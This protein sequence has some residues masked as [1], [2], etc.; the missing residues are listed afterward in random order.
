MSTLTHPFSGILLC[1]SV[2]YQIWVYIKNAINK[3]NVFVNSVVGARYAFDV[4]CLSGH[5]QTLQFSFIKK[6]VSKVNCAI[7]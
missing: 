2:D 4:S 3:F 7:D 1:L 6:S 5:R